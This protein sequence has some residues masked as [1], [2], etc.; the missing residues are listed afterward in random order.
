VK[1]SFIDFQLWEGGN[2]F[3]FSA[4]STDGFHGG[5]L[6]VMPPCCAEGEYLVG[7]ALQA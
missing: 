5:A 1:I 2:G 7:L 4:L 3:I 6:R